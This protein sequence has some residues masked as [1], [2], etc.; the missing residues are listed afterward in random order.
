MIR[1]QPCNC[2]VSFAEFAVTR[3]FIFVSNKIN[4]D[5]TFSECSQHSERCQTPTYN[6]NGVF[7]FFRFYRV[8]TISS[9]PVLN[10]SGREIT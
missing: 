9:H 10:L 7:G 2:E 8:H 5:A 1:P 6:Y 3:S 4:I